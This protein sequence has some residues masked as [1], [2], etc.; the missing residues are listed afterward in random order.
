MIPDRYIVAASDLQATFT[1]AQQRFGVAILAI[2]VHGLFGCKRLHPDSETH[3]SC[4]MGVGG[5]V[6]VA[7]E[8]AHADTAGD[9]AAA[10]AAAWTNDAKLSG[11]EGD[12][13]GA[14][15]A[16]DYQYDWKA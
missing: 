3:R 14:G 1:G 13:D 10:D 6:R 16:K 2:L 5:S 15:I 8:A 11:V 4:E 12:V 7:P 9:A